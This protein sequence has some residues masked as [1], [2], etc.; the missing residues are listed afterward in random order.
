[1]LKTLLQNSIKNLVRNKDRVALSF[2]GGTDSLCILFSCLDLDIRPTLYT[3]YVD[4]YPSEDLKIAKGI[5]EHYNL[6]LVKCKI[7]KDLETL[8]KD[9]LHMM[10]LS[11]QGKVN[12]QC[13]HGHLYVAKKVKEKQILNGSGIDGI[14]GTY[15]TF[16]FD[17]SRDSKWIFDDKRQ[18][19]IDNKNDDAMQYQSII[20]GGHGVDVLFPYRDKLILD[21][22]MQYG[23]AQINKPRNKHVIT[24]CYNQFTWKGVYRPRGSQQIK[25]GTRD[26]HDMLISSNW[27]TKGR[28][29]VIEIYKDVR[30]SLNGN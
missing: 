21:S 20:Y 10:E 7:P 11:I 18:K 19:H 12:L 29:R 5:A 9:I 28:K 30:E 1:M 2:S 16:A 3:Y 25:A 26:L 8:K 24:K 6:K 13:C 4:G 15:K 17:G 23:W 14:Y 22:L 27:N